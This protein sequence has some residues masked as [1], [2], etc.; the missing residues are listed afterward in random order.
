MIEGFIYTKRDL[1]SKDTLI[2]YV[3]AVSPDYQRMGIGASL[4]KHAIDG[5]KLKCD[6]RI[7]VIES[8]VNFRSA[9]I[10]YKKVVFRH[11][12]TLENYYSNGQHKLIFT[13]EA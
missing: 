3:L 4:L 7:I 5:M 10:L 11:E 12:D 13:M 9:H 6:T 8:S 2:I 1:F